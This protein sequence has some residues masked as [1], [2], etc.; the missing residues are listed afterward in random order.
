MFGFDNMLKSLPV[1]DIGCG[2]YSNIDVSQL[3]Q[4]PSL[5]GPYLLQKPIENVIF[6]IKVSGKN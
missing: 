2:V 6:N 3:S 1:C 4:Y 5:S